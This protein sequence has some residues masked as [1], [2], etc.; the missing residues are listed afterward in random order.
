MLVV[1][2][3]RW[4]LMHEL[5]DE[6]EPDLGTLLALL[7]PV[8]LV[9]V[10]GYKRDAHAKIEVHR[11]GNGKPFLFPYDASIVALASDAP[12][13]FGPLPRVLLDD[14]EAIAALAL[15]EALPLDETRRRLASMAARE[16]P[17][18]V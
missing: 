9:L 3:K 10:E 14:I 2:A 13:P 12:P 7:A 15:A 18:A 16:E 8:D 6:A 4:A 5:R 1:S 17:P 11:V